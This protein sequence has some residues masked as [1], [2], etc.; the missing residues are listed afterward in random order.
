ML[1][2]QQVG[3]YVKSDLFVKDELHFEL[4]ISEVF[5]LVYELFDSILPYEMIKIKRAFT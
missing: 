2:I 5:L 4:Q 3:L 1:E